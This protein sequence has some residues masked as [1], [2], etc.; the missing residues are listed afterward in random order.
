MVVLKNI[1]DTQKTCWGIIRKNEQNFHLF[2][3]LTA[4]KK[5]SSNRKELL[6]TNKS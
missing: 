1:Y 3:S 6:S 2:P 5:T 4:K